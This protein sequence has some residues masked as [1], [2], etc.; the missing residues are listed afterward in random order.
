MEQFLTPFVAVL[1][2]VLTPVIGEERSSLMSGYALKCIQGDEELWKTFWIFSVGVPVV[3]ALLVLFPLA[4]TGR[5]GYSL[6]LILLVPYMVW[7][8]T[9]VWYCSNNIEADEVYGIQKEYLTIA[10]KVAVVLSV[11]NIFLQLF[12]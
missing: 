7:A 5:L 1:Q 9:S 12:A 10:A 2:K 6:G 8:L 3:Y 11:F 4:M